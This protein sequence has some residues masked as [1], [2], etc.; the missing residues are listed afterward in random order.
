MKVLIVA[1]TRQGNGACIGAISSEGRSIRLVAADP[2]DERWGLA[3]D[4]GDLRASI[5]LSTFRW[6][7]VL[8]AR[9]RRAVRRGFRKQ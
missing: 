1:K 9:Q 3:F 4:V 5:A 8:A 6:L 7:I 2:K